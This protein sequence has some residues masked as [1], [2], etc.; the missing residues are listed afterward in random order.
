M[1]CAYLQGSVKDAAR[2]RRRLVKSKGYAPPHV[3][4]GLGK[5]RLHEK[6]SA[7][8]EPRSR[9]DLSDLNP[10]SKSALMAKLCVL[11]QMKVLFHHFPV[12]KAGRRYRRA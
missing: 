6:S 10:V 3:L 4:P 12:S 5:Q 8:S 2:Y 1:R 7:A 11:T 9:N